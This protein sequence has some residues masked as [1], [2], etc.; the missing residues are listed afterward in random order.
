MSVA[1]KNYIGVGLVGLA[2]IA[3]WVFGI[4]TWDRISLLSDAV[5]AREDMLLSR[6]EILKKIEDL[7]NQYQQ[8]SSDVSKISSV[9]PNAKGTA[10]LISTI[11][12]VT[13]Q[14]GLQLVEIT[15][16]ELS[17][18]GQELQTVFVELGLTGNYL[19]LTTF[20][21]LIEKNLRL[22]DVFELSISQSSIP[23]NQIV[24]NFRLKANMYYIK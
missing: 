5:I 8:R 19:S 10:E 21:D 15:M 2:T 3:F 23:G 22:M 24:L 1:N 18:Q 20:L 9:V 4:P 16:G 11:E 17:N 12:T 7:H 6:M 13:Q 14:A